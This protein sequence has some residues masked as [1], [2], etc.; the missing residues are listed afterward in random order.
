MVVM[1]GL[2]LVRVEGQPE[3]S[4]AVALTLRDYGLKCQKA[5]GDVTLT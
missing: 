2:V 3:L 1:A 5:A 4:G